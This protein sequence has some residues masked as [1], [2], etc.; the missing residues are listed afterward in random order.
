MTSSGATEQQ[1]ATED[2][3]LDAMIDQNPNALR[4]HNARFA[5]YGTHPWAVLNS[6]RRA[7]G[8]V[9]LAAADLAMAAN[10]ASG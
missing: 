1:L 6:M 2:A 4:H 9:T 3:A 5:G 7:T 8:D 10:T